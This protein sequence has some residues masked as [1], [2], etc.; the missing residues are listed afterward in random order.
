M[1]FDYNDL[2]TKLKKDPSEVKPKVDKFAAEIK[3]E[4]TDIY[5]PDQIDE[6]VEKVVLKNIKKIFQLSGLAYAEDQAEKG[7]INT[8]NAIILGVSPTD[9]RNSY[10]KWLLR[11]EYKKD[12]KGTVK[13]GKVREA[14][15][16]NGNVYAVPLD[17]EPMIKRKDKDGNNVEVAN[18]NLGKD[19]PDSLKVTLPLI[20]ASVDGNST[21]KFAM[22]SM[23]WDDNMLN[24]P[25]IGKKSTV[26]GRVNE[27][28]DE[29]KF[30]VSKDA[31]KGNDIYQKA[32]DVA[33]RVLPTTDVWMD[34]VE[35]VS[36]PITEEVDGKTKNI[37]TKFATKGNVQ[38]VDIQEQ[39]RYNGDKYL[40]AKVRIGDVDVI[41]G[42]NLGTSYDNTVAYVS[43]NIQTGDE[44]VVFGCKKSFAKTDNNN[45]PL[46]DE[47]GNKVM[48]AYY[49]LWGI[50]KAFD[51]KKD[52]INARLRAK[53]LI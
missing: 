5:P 13:A 32:Y 16:K 6:E 28:G 7:N 15:S 21:E 39:T 12:P 2:A 48:I 37:Y 27:D 8:V 46:L 23:S 50:I 35:V 42:I 11:E 34:L 45:K 29:V 40:K 43:E 52:E 33:M 10:K 49:E 53:G 24:H 19:I 36:T 38:K 9:D 47:T 30:S 18:P 25:D 41:D 44:V 3:A 17:Y 26:Y 31:Y 4:L 1:A 14:V 20:I 51:N 22:A